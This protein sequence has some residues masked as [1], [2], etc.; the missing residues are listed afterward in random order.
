MKETQ[1]PLILSLDTATPTGSV[2]LLRGEQLL[3]ERTWGGEAKG[4]HSAHVLQEIDLALTEAQVKLKQVELFAASTGPGS[5]TGL[6][7]GLSIIKAFAATLRRPCAGV[8]TLAAL[9]RGCK[10]AHEQIIVI[11]PA[12]R[13]ELFTQR[14]R[15]SPEREVFELDE[16][17]HLKP[18]ALMNNVLALSG[19]VLWTGPGATLY[20]TQLTEY[21]R[22]NRKENDWLILTEPS[23]IAADAGALA[24]QLYLKNKLLTAEELSAS[25]VRRAD[26]RLPEVQ[27][28]ASL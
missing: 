21:A 24:Y 11:L 1:H 20:H 28:T 19:A 3:S 9:A 23:N 18:E 7:I 8:S 5:F 17:A 4:S 2:A 10:L 27:L 22:Q 16:P 26:A 14:F 15:V 6:R 12:G 25:Y 13:G